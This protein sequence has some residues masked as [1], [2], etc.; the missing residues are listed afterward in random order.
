MKDDAAISNLTKLVSDLWKQAVDHDLARSSEVSFD[1][2]LGA[3]YS[4][5]FRA[6]QCAITE[7]GIEI[8]EIALGELQKLINKN[9]V[10]Q[11]DEE[12]E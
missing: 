10:G 7:E 5:A 3:Q 8:V 4:I 9:F 1:T 12:N 6:G 2:F 11:E